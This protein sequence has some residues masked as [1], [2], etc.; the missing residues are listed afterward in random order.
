MEEFL[1]LLETVLRTFEVG[2]NP[3]SFLVLVGLAFARMLSF[4]VVV[5]FFGGAAVPARVKVATATAFVIILYPSLE[6]GLPQNNQPL[7]FGPIGFIALLAKEAFVGFTLGFVASLVFEAIQVAGRII[8]FQRGS[9][10]A[11]MY[12]PQLQTRVSELGQ[13]KL[14]FAIVLFLL[15]GAHHFFISALLRSFEVVPAFGFPHLQAG[16]TPAAA[17]MTR[18][19]GGVLA[20]GIQLA[21]PAMIALL[22]TDLFFGI[23]NRVAPQINVFFLSLPVKMA[24]GLVVVLIALPL[25]KERYIYYFKEAYLSFEAIIRALGATY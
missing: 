12:A 19:T 7:G 3:Q 15:I 8:D 21:A 4:L 24:V 14:Q 23:I 18:L 11:E 5:P 2:Q 25:F 16:W 9:T 6:A 13:F 22:L 1:K 17:F 10:M 20:V